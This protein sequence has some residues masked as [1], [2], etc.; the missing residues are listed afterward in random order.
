M[1]PIP[2]PIDL[3]IFEDLVCEVTDVNNVWNVR[4][5]LLP[6]K[7]RK[8]L[9]E[10][11][12]LVSKLELA[13]PYRVI[14]FS[15]WASDEHQ[16]WKVLTNDELLSS[17]DDELINGAWALFFFRFQPDTEKLLMLVPDD[18]SNASSAMQTVRS[19]GA[20]AAI[21]SWYDNYEWMVVLPFSEKN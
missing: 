15:E 4:M 12:S 19:I 1:N 11:I 7:N 13:L 5:P 17:I 16:G 14:W 2:V 21:W 6:W 10:R 3:A 18:P 8:A 20:S 9:R